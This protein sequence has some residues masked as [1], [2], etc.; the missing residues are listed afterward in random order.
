V[1][2]ARKARTRKTRV[3]IGRHCGGTQNLLARNRF[4]SWL[5][6]GYSTEL[7]AGALA[8]DVEATVTHAGDAMQRVHI[9]PGKA[10][11]RFCGE[12]ISTNPS[13]RTSPRSILV[14]DRSTCPPHS[15]ESAQAPKRARRSRTR[16]AALQNTGLAGAR[17]LVSP[18][19]RPDEP[20]LRMERVIL[21]GAE[22]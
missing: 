1:S 15:C 12:H 22:L 9:S 20:G 21:I 18:D 8:L 4:R 5:L 16:V 3:E 11:C 2:C 7:A 14:R 6:R 10:L 13:P 19:S 17:R